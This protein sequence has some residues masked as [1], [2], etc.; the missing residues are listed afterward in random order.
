[1]DTRSPEELLT[2]QVLII[3]H[4]YLVTLGTLGSLDPPDWSLSGYGT[5]SVIKWAKEVNCGKV[6]FELETDII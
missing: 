4:N 2:E 1:M 3:S 6:D 5:V